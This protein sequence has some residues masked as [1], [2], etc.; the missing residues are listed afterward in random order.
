MKFSKIMVLSFSCLLLSSVANAQQ[1][2]GSLK[3]EVA[4]LREDIQILQRDA[5][6]SKGDGNAPTSSGD[7][8][9]R[10]G[11]FD[12]NLRQINGKIDELTFKIKS[13]DDKMN[14]INRD[15][16]V[17]IKMLEGAPIS[18]G[19]GGNQ[20]MDL[21][22]EKFVAPVAKNAPKSI[23]GDAISEGDDLPTVQTKSANEMYQTGLEAIK[24]SNYDVAEQNFESI[25]RRFPKDKLAGNAQYWLGE[26]YYGR[27]DYQKAAVAFAK[28]YQ[29]Y[30]SGPKGADSLLKLGMSMRELKK[31]AEACTAFS[32]MKT[33]F[34]KAAE[35]TLVKAETEA[36][37]LSCK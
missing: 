7:V 26:V 31:I 18:G 22:K 11:E 37:K 25:L 17:R 20:D 33:E 14:M 28:G 30:K 2:G 21:R 4:A 9:M 29:N 35:T 19:A 23:V 34:P 36:K 16:D 5:Y 8:A 10:V 24:S 3:D 6:R 13:L 27:K 12:E 1:Y 32:S 15:I